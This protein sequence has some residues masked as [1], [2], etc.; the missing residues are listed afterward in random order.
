[1]K[2]FLFYLSF[3]ILAVIIYSP[4]NVLA[5]NIFVDQSLQNDCIASNYSI[6]SRT[7]GGS[8]GDS[9]DTIQEAINASGVGDTIHMR[10][11]TYNISSHGTSHS[12]G[13]YIRIDPRTKSGTGWTPGNYTTLQSYAGEWAII[14]GENSIGNDYPARGAIGYGE[15]TSSNVSDLA[16][17]KFE[18]FEIKNCES[19]DNSRAAAFG[20]NGGPIWYRYLYIHDNTASDGSNNPSGI[21]MEHMHD[22]IIEYCWFYNNGTEITNQ[23][24]NSADITS[25]SDYGYQSSIAGGSTPFSNSHVA[26]EGNIIRY[27]YFAGGSH[28]FKNKG[29]QLLS[30]RGAHVSDT[31]KSMGDQIH[32]NI[33]QNYGYGGIM[34]RTDFS[35]IHHNILDDG[36]WGIMLGYEDPSG[37][38]HKQMAYNNTITDTVSRAG[39]SVDNGISR[40]YASNWSQGS[41]PYPIFGY[42]YNNIIDNCSAGRDSD[43]SMSAGVQSGGNSMDLS[44]YY[45]SNNYFY[46]PP[47]SDIISLVYDTPVSAANYFTQSEFESQS[48]SAAPRVVYMNSYDSANPL[49]LGTSG[50]EKYLINPTHLIENGVTVVDGGI[51]GSHPYLSGVS[52]PSYIGAVNPADNTWVAGILSLSVSYM[53]GASDDPN[54]VEG[55]GAPS[56]PII[57][58]PSNLKSLPE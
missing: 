42:D 39:I 18:R 5:A 9:Y 41:T 2:L 44:N 28:G 13:Y 51:G 52:I 30:G 22:C 19:V 14:D 26:T 43:A 27:N 40:K 7:C 33:F 24:K 45:N 55:S 31:Y 49:Y 16:Y 57:I 32:H 21:R 54:W 10:G 23:E 11:G 4:V 37:T 35:Q 36:T 29:A 8:D 1:M 50:A 46:R 20:I 12:G 47:S 3:I 17:W 38:I 56:L 34:S 53:T 48:Y 58:A 15:S 25:I 6:S